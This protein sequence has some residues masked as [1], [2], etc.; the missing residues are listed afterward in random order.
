ML[1]PMD[2]GDINDELDDDKL[3]HSIESS[4]KSGEWR[5]DNATFAD[6]RLQSLAKQLAEPPRTSY[7]Q[8][9]LLELDRR[10]AEKTQRD[11]DKARRD[12]AEATAPAFADAAR[13]SPTVDW[14][15]TI[16]KPAA[17]AA[18][19]T[20]PGAAPAEAVTCSVAWAHVLGVAFALFAATLAVQIAIGG[21]QMSLAVRA[22]IAAI[23]T[24]I[25]W[26]AFGA[27]RYRSAAV[28]GGAH[29]IAFVSTG[30]ASSG[31]EVFAAFLGAMIVLLGA[32]AIGM[33]RER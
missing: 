20:G 1:E 31:P 16:V 22:T 24:G 32:G 29:L 15:K 23:A 2:P 14:R 5:D 3:R 17:P 11:A 30:S 4:T 25:A 10:D 27:G 19:T 7:T 26:K 21:W 28:A 13:E 6:P 18:A 33:A 9:R 12:A 8:R